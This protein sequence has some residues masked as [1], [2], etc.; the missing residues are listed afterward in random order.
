MKTILHGLRHSA[1]ALVILTGLSGCTTTSP[2]AVPHAP[3]DA[4]QPQELVE[5]LQMF[6][7]ASAGQRRWVIALPAREHEDQFKIELLPTIRIRTDCNRYLASAKVQ[8]H[9]VQGWGYTYEVM[10]APGPVVSTMM[11][12]P[13]DTWQERDV[14]VHAGLE[15]RRYNS[16]IPIVFYTPQAVTLRYRLWRVQDLPGADNTEP[17]GIL[18]T[19]Y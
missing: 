18:A 12:C 6:P 14:P 7:A 4:T 1:L 19:P 9:V 2:V 16:K 17:P 10:D 15:L 11:G 3:A 5:L 13:E 8:S